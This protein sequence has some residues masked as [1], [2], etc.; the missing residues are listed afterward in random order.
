MTRNKGQLFAPK[1]EVRD[2]LEAPP[3]PP[4]HEQGADRPGR[5]FESATTKRSAVEQTDWHEEAE[6]AF[7]VQVAA[8]L[9]KLCQAQK[10]QK[11][12]L[13]AAPRALAVLRA[14]MPACLSRKRVAEVDKD[15]T[16]HPISEVERLLAEL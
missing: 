8:H 14:N 6:V 10:V 13:V 5:S 1:L 9:E 2:I 15:Y 12:V 7:L 16:K 4:T 11:L 3:N